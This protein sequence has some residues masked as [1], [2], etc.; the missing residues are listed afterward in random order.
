MPK[1]TLTEKQK[2]QE[3]LQR[4]I[5]AS[6]YLTGI[7]TYQKLAGLLLMS[8]RALRDKIRGKSEFKHSELSTLFRVLRF[9]D[10]KILDVVKRS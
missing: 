3:L 6:L 2:K 8:E 10:D 5:K 9:D 1:V 4:Y 7:E